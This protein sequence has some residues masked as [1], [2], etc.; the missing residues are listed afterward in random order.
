MTNIESGLLAL[1]FSI[2][3]GTAMTYIN[4]RFKSADDK[5]AAR[6]T[7]SAAQIEAD[8]HSEARLF[9]RIHELE[10]IN[11]EC[12]ESLNTARAEK[13]ALEGKLY[14]ETARLELSE[15]RRV[16]VETDYE[17]VTGQLAECHEALNQAKAAAVNNG[18]S[19][20]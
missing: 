10:E 19:A 14:R 1:A 5:N 8:D 13:V 7:R 12:Y 20:T 18:T 6:D 2:A 16:Q 11:R 15:A 17:R 3:G 9:V 4:R